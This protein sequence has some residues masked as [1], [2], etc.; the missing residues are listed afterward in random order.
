MTR[1][2]HPP[3]GAAYRDALWQFAQTARRPGTL[4]EEMA[5][6]IDAIAYP[7]S[8]RA[9]ARATL[10]DMA[11]LMCK[12]LDGVGPGYDTAFT[13]M[14]V[15]SMEMGFQ[16]NREQ[17]DE[18]D[19][20]YLSRVLDRRTGLP[21]LLSLVCVAIGRRLGLEIGGVGFP[22]HFMAAMRH[23]ESDWLL[24]PFNGQVMALEG[25]DEYL[26]ALFGQQVSI[27]P[28]MYAPCTTVQWAQRILNNLRNVYRASNRYR[29]AARV[30]DFM[31]TLVPTSPPLW[32]DRALVHSH[33]EHWEQTLY[34]LRRYFF[35]RGQYSLIF[36]PDAAR[37]QLLQASSMQ[38]RQLFALYQK[39]QTLVTRLN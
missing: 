32:R 3:A 24:D 20:S 5:L 7:L 4:P 19:N 22:G 39:A 30:L 21:I 16:G 31:V 14:Q 2:R 17:Y 11:T 27:P 1:F 26:S 29:D 15:F 25:A 34:D 8:D 9:A 28:E 18:P 35:L 37:A 36:G 6:L 10:D 13:F 12:R 38:D 33:A 23:D